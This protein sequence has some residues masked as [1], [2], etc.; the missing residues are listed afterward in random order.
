M[1]HPRLLLHITSWVSYPE[2]YPLRFSGQGQPVWNLA[3]IR[4]HVFKTKITA[5]RFTAGQAKENMRQ[6]SKAP[7]R[8]FECQVPASSGAGRSQ[9]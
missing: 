2:V 1:Q 4:Y 8:F 9:L 3:F 7:G 6:R 5:R